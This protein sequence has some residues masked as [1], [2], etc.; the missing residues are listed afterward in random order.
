MVLLTEGLL[1]GIIGQDTRT[2]AM[3]LRLYDLDIVVWSDE[4]LRS[5][6]KHREGMIGKWQRMTRNGKNST[7]EIS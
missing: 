1:C 2:S 7:G 3:M 4:G 5:Y 6:C